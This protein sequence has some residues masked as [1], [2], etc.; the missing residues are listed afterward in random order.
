MGLSSETMH[1]GE[2]PT[3]DFD[4]ITSQSLVDHSP[5]CIFSFLDTPI[6]T[7]ILVGD[8]MALLYFD[9]PNAL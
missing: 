6:S 4:K 8:F 9:I 2:Y 7:H 3:K 5:T 1:G